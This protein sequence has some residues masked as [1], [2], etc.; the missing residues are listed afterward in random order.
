MGRRRMKRGIFTLVVGISLLNWIWLFAGGKIT[1]FTL[2]PGFNRVVVKWE[3]ENETG[4]EKYVVQ[5]SFDNNNFS[6]LADVEP[7]K[8]NERIK[9]YQYVDKTV[10]KVS[11]G[12]RTFFYRLKIVNKDKSVT[13]SKVEHVTPTVS[14]ARQTWGMIK[15]MFR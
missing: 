5:R 1:K 11:A 14:S 2:E 12:G 8:T 10:F 15:A 4:V 13:Y 9:K 3:V 7:K 6:N